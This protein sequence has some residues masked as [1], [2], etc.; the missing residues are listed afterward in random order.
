MSDTT[1]PA[2]GY[3]AD[4]LGRAQKCWDA[5]MSVTGADDRF[6]AERL[7][8]A[9]FMHHVTTSVLLENL[10]R[11]D[12]ELADRLT[13]WMLTPDGVFSDGY[14]GELLYEWRRQVAAGEP[15]APIG[16]DGSP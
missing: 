7:H 1:T 13:G 5:A 15:L 16:P 4:A 6:P 2:Q 14:A 10:R 9:W 8:I 3:I 12:P 11:L